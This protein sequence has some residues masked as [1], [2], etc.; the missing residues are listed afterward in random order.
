M[1]EDKAK[2]ITVLRKIKVRYN[3]FLAANKMK[4]KLV[5]YVVSILIII[6]FLFL[7][8]YFC[9]KVIAAGSTS[10]TY[11]KPC[12]DTYCTPNHLG[13]NCSVVCPCNTG[14]TQTSDSVCAGSNQCKTT[15]QK[16]TSPSPSP[17][18][19][20]SMPTM[21][22]S[23]SPSPSCR[24]CLLPDD[25]DEFTQICNWDGNPLTIGCCVPK[26]PSTT[27]GTT[28]P[29]TQTAPMYP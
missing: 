23:P 26:P 29:A 11:T 6:G 8:P 25:C 21:T 12:F 9:K 4:N 3:N 20:P 10:S 13:W 16:A 14:D 28:Q 2:G 19:S 7:T 15:C 24:G 22:P 18:P 5:I 27:T 17:S 1:L